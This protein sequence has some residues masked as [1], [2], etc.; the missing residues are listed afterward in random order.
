LAVLATSTVSDLLRASE[1]HPVVLIYGSDESAVRE[2]ASGLVKAAAGS[3]D[4]PFAVTRLEDSQLLKNKGLLAEE[5][6]AMPL[7]GGRRVVW[8]T[9]VAQGFLAAVQPLLES[10]TKLNLIVAVAGALAKSSALRTLFEKSTKAAIVPIYEDDPE[11]VRRVIVEHLRGANLAAADDAIER[12]TELT[13]PARAQ[14]RQE[15]TKLALYCANRREVTIEDVEA[16]CGEATEPSA[17]D[18]C[19]AAFGGKLEDVDQHMRRLAA[20]G[21]AGGQLVS[22]LLAHAA[23]LREMCAAMAAGKPA[24]LVMGAVRPP[25][26]FKRK[27]AIAQQLDLWDLPALDRAATTLMAAVVQTREQRDLENDIAQRSILSIA[28]SAGRR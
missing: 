16:V 11:R 21:L 17:D 12:L 20:A 2:L 8:V 26:F 23:R 13:G 14:L 25:I 22:S 5:A 1:R 19:D 15:L 28:R 24:S 7:L 6:A 3:L 10:Q 4:D 9:G 18:V 27:S